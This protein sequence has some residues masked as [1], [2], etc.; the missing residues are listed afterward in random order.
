MLQPQNLFNPSQDTVL[1]NQLIHENLQLR[2][3]QINGHATG[4][5]VD[6]DIN[7]YLNGDDNLIQTQKQPLIQHEEIQENNVEETKCNIEKAA[8]TLQ[9]HS[10]QSGESIK[11]SWAKIIFNSSNTANQIVS[12][13]P[14][15]NATIRPQSATQAS[16][17]QHVTAKPVNKAN[18][19]LRDRN[20][21]VP[22]KP[23]SENSPTNT[24]NENGSMYTTGKPSR[25]SNRSKDS[26]QLKEARFNE[27]NFGSGEDTEKRF[28][29]Y[30]DNHQIFVG[31]LQPDITEKEL[32]AYFNQYG[33]IYE[34]R[35]NA[36]TKQQSARKLPNYGFIVFETKEA[37]EEVLRIS[38]ET[39]LTMKN[40][41]GVE[42]RLNI[43]EKRARQP[44]S[45]NQ[46]PPRNNRSSSNS[47]RNK[48]SGIDSQ[49]SNVRPVSAVKKPNVVTSNGTPMNTLSRKP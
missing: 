2:T 48:N 20:Q 44:L 37:V 11:S 21:H 7:T 26:Y 4:S 5:L 28:G 17:S 16:Q 34:A 1:S 10:Q 31:N 8:E 14:S 41:K 13:Q 30:P 9:T 46:K 42:Y 35:I 18:S 24:T 29:K 47:S 33:S 40:E 6:N 23:N 15:V 45:S 12:S 19:Q 27:N 32:K 22:A 39:Q 49:S 38:K 43:E 3:S 36:N 25:H